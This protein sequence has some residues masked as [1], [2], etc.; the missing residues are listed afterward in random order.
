MLLGISC[1]FYWHIVRSQIVLPSLI[2][3]TLI[4]PSVKAHSAKNNHSRSRIRKSRRCLSTLILSRNSWDDG[5]RRAYAGTLSYDI[6]LKL[7]FPSTYNNAQKDKFVPVSIA[8]LGI[9]SLMAF[10][11]APIAEEWACGQL[12]PRRCSTDE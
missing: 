4:R 1:S 11:E 9:G 3:I 12:N 5:S 2:S 7:S 6:K 10:E 8:T